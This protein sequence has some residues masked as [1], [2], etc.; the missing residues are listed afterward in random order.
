MKSASVGVFLLCLLFFLKSLNATEE[1]FENASWAQK[2]KVQ[3]E[4]RKFYE[5]T[6][7]WVIDAHND[8]PMKY[9]EYSSLRVFDQPTIDFISTA[10]QPEYHMDT[11]IE[12]LVEGKARGVFWSAYVSCE[13]QGKDAVLATLEQIDVVHRLIDRYDDAL[14]SAQSVADVEEARQ[15]GKIASL[16]GVEGGH[17]MANSLGALRMF[18]ALGVRYMTLTHNCDTEWAQ[19]HVSDVPD[20]GLTPF[21]KAVVLEMNRLGMLV[22]LS[23]VAATTMREAIEASVSPVIFSHSDVFA[24]CEKTRNVPDDVLDMLKAN[25]GVL[26]VNFYSSFVKCQGQVTVSNVADVVDYIAQRIGVDHVGIG[27]DFD[28]SGYNLPERLSDV[29][30]FSNLFSELLC[31]GWNFVDLGKLASGNILRVLKEVENVSKELRN[32]PPV[33]EILVAQLNNA[34]AVDDIYSVPFEPRDDDD[35]ET[36]D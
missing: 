27:S 3:D 6:E 17:S 11:D 7:N 13:H 33:E 24:L 4:L 30:M 29:S 31:R 20:Y 5:S 22:D 21:G 34:C 9:R 35:E 14:M 26:Q 36:Q 10:N 18:Y 19:S 16:I 23:H 15:Q 32:Q 1:C 8:V 25:R 12:R 28:G 2:L